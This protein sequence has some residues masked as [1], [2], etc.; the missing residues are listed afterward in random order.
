MNCRGHQQG[1]QRHTEEEAQAHEL[2]SG[3]RR[4]GAAVG[5]GSGDTSPKRV[6]KVAVVI[7]FVWP[8]YCSAKPGSFS[9]PTR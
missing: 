3:E 4:E 2:S 8:I 1:Q 7:G 5:R 6:F 9:A